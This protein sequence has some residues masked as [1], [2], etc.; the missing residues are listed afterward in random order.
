MNKFRKVTIIHIPN[1]N[2]KKASIY[3]HEGKYYVLESIFTA[4]EIFM[5]NNKKYSEV[6]CLNLN[7]ENEF[8]HSI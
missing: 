2:H 1:S 7:L 8:W 5:F 6:K 4:Y 3:E